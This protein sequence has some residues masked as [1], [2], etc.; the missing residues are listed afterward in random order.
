MVSAVLCGKFVLNQMH[1]SFKSFVSDLVFNVST[2]S[3]HHLVCN[4][5]M[6]L[7]SVPISV[8]LA[9]VLV[10]VNVVKSPISD[11]KS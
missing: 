6:S 7:E 8:S 1:M 5:V 9:P 11:F 2:K 4:C 10:H 3:N